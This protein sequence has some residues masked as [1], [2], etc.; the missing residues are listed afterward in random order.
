MSDSKKKKINIKSRI[1]VAQTCQER[2]PM[3]WVRVWAMQNACESPHKGRNP[4]LDVCPN[5]RS[6]VVNGSDPCMGVQQPDFEIPPAGSGQVV[7]CSTAL[8]FLEIPK[9]LL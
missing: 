6:F 7:C 3:D 1:P 8:V 4:K 9:P 2:H 5:Y